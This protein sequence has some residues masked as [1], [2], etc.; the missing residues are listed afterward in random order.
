MKKRIL[1]ASMA[2]ALVLSGCGGGGGGAASGGGDSSGGSSGGSTGGTPT[3]IQICGATSGGTYFLIANGLCQLLNDTM[4]DVFNATAQSTGGTPENIRLMQAG[5]TDFAFG[6][7]G[8]A[9]EAYEGTGSFEGD[10]QPNI[11]AVTYVYPNVMQ[12]AVRNG[13]GIESF[14]DFAGKTFCAGA[15]GS[16]T[17]LNTRDMFEACGLTYDDVRIEYT[18]E[19]QSTEL[20]QN[21]QADGANLVAAIGA[22]SVTELYSTGDYHL[23]SFS[24]EELDAILA[25]N[26]SYYAYTIPAGTYANQEEDI[27]T[28]AIA[29]YIF[30]RADLDEDIVYNFV[31]CIYDN[32]DD[33]Y[34]IHSI[35]EGNITLENVANGLTIPM[36]PGAEKYYKE[37]GAME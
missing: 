14:A 17:E 31:K 2:L 4:P 11:A 18:S 33:V 5:E 16:A 35:C 20:M 25:M 1:A 10:P 36:H 34:A 30:C 27:N 32:L 3:N 6:Q 22:A 23:L 28:F 37:V 19:S 29:N 26:D 8:V 15:S 7:A 24:D 9:K 12:I 13:S 21:N